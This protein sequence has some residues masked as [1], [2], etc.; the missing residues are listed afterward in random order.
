[1]RNH[2]LRQYSKGDP[3]QEDYKKPLT[4]VNMGV[5]MRDGVNQ[6]LFMNV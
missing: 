6:K 3:L 4:S 2:N 1:M 5:K